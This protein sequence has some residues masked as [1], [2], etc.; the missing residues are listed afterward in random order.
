MKGFLRA[1]F[2]ILLLAANALSA[3]AHL[4]RYMD[5]PQPVG[6]GDLSFLVWNVYT[7]TLYAPAG[8]WRPDGPFALHIVYHMELKGADIASRSVDEMRRQGLDDP[9]TLRRFGALMEAIFPDVVKD[10]TLTGVRDTAGGTLFYRDGVFIGGVREQ[11]FTDRFFAI[12][13]SPETSE[14]KLRARLLGGS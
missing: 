1:W 11:E 9:E 7:A 6:S 3:P 10:T 8:S 5:N 2:L 13:L 14:P 12:W 4:Y